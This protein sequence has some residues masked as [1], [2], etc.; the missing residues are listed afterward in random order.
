MRA[1]ST[2]LREVE[3][4]RSEA[5]RR[6]VSRAARTSANREIYLHKSVSMMRRSIACLAADWLVGGDRR[7]AAAERIY[8][9][10]TDLIAHDGLGGLRRRQHWRRVFTAPARRSTAM[11]A[12]RPRFAR[13]YWSAP[14]PGSS[15]RSSAPSTTERVATES[16][17]R[18]R[19][20]SEEIRSDPLGRLMIELD[21]RCRGDDVAHRIS[22]RRRVRAGYQRTRRGRPAGGTVDR[23]YRDGDCCTGPSTMP[24]S[25]A[26][27]L[28]RFVSPAFAS[29]AVES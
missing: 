11:P 16:S 1:A 25:S 18:S 9:A 28:E 4:R 26:D 19:W 23:P 2:V 20:R 8:D 27:V 21:S 29:A 3:N 6:A 13:P 12:A 24:K 5:V 15:R 14:Q 17:P 7:T 10:A 22:G